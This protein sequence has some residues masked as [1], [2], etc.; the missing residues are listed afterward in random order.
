LQNTRK[1]VGKRP[2]KY[3]RRRSIK[4]M[5]MA[6]RLVALPEVSNTLTLRSFIPT[7]QEQKMRR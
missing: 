2:P 7:D 6:K 1:P 3:W 5:P 4:P